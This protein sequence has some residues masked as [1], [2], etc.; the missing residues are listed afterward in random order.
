LQLRAT[1]S[2]DLKRMGESGRNYYF[3]NFDPTL[4]ARQLLERLDEV[5]NRSSN[6]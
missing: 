1:S 4:L 5:V 3:E 6:Q 2:E